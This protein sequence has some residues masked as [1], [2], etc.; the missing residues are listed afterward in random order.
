MPI[1]YCSGIYS[2]TTFVNDGSAG[3][4]TLYYPLTVNVY[5]SARLSPS[6][7]ARGRLPRVT[8][9]YEGQ[10]TPGLFVL[11]TAAHSRD[12][13]SSAGGFIH[14]FRYTGDDSRLSMFLEVPRN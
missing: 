4:Y 3:W 11:G 9:W 1:M 7:E 8:A 12:Y 10:G 14:G 5:S 13:R 2:P 6:A